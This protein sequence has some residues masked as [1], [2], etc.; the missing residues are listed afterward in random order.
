MTYHYSNLLE[1]FLLNFSGASEAEK[2]ILSLP[3]TYYA[4]G[5]KVL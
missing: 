4:M 1:M 3:L 5:Q 2:N